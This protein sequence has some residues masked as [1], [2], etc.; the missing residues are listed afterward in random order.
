MDIIR[1][2]KENLESDINGLGY[3]LVDIEFVNEG[4]NKQRWRNHN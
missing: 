1:K 3:E 2:L 4:K